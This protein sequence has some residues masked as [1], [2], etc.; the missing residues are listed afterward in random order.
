MCFTAILVLTSSCS[1]E[2]DSNVVQINELTPDL[3]GEIHN[4]AMTNFKNNFDLNQNLNSDESKELIINF[5]INFLES[6]LN[7][8]GINFNKEFDMVFYKNLLD[9]ESLA[10]HYFYGNNDYLGKNSSLSDLE[11]YNAYQIVD[12]MFESNYINQN[13]ELILKQI[14]EYH[15][16]NYEFNL[17]DIELR[18]NIINLKNNFYAEN[19]DMKSFG[20]IYVA[21]ALELALK[22][23]KWWEEN[24]SNNTRNNYY[25]NSKTM[26]APWIAADIV[27]GIGSG[28]INLIEQ[29]LTNE[30]GQ[31]ADAESVAWAML[32]G[33]VISSVSPWSK[34][35][36]W[37]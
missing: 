13:E 8:R 11:N 35:A 14:I 37:F 32:K 29:G 15:K 1:E 12:Y 20:A 17:S 23:N 18:D 22:S 33:A 26:I 36:S 34:I 25:E 7:K 4:K 19:P 16:Q 2:A 28:F 9:T 3:V 5:N 24:L 6:E 31:T 21:N 30:P 10:N 27:G